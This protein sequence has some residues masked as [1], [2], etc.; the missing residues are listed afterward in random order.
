MSPT[1]LFDDARK[2]AEAAGYLLPDNTCTH[3]VPVSGTHC[4]ECN[5]SRLV[6]EF[7]AQ[8]KRSDPLTG[9]QKYVKGLAEDLLKQCEEN[10]EL[11]LLL[12][13]LVS[14]DPC[15]L[16]HHGHCQEHMWA[17]KGECVHSRARKL[18][19]WPDTSQMPEQCR[20]LGY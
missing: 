20:Q 10:A 11:K 4:P 14:S 18:L 19:G 12:G 2:R 9:P 7:A 17:G 8:L 1:N 5:A 15:R 6:I 16:D 13:Q 3:A